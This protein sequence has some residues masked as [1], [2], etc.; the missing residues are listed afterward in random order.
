LN[1]PDLTIAIA[2]AR[3]GQIASLLRPTAIT[4]SPAVS[5]TA[6]LV[7]YNPTGSFLSSSL[8]FGMPRAS[9]V[10]S[11]LLR[12]TPAMALREFESIALHLANFSGPTIAMQDSLGG[13]SGGIF[14]AVF[15]NECPG[16]TL[17]LTL[18]KGEGL[19]AFEPVEIVIP[20]A[21]MITLPETGVR[22]GYTLHPAPFTPHSTT[23]ALHPT[24]YT[25]H[26]T[27]YTLLTAPYT[28]HTAPHTLRLSHCTL[29]PAPFTLHST[30]HTRHSKPYTRHPTHSTP[31]PETLG[32]LGSPSRATQWLVQWR[33]RL[34]RTC[35]L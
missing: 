8:A 23:Y 26:P 35:C 10:S 13:A 11:L 4:S 7:P 12:F 28:L 27:P 32:T 30:S 3:D 31:N 6:T 24:P 33:N 34:W 17:T 18:R 1:A 19:A 2:G 16:R 9:T 22:F 25:L 20:E 21:A 5:G 15:S 14:F 29:H